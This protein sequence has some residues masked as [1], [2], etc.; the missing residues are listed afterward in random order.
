[1]KSFCVNI[2]WHGLSNLYESLASQFLA[3]L[4]IV[5]KI[6]S[7]NGLKTSCQTRKKE[8][9]KEKKKDQKKRKP[10]GSGKKEHSQE[11]LGGKDHFNKPKK[12]LPLHLKSKLPEK[13]SPL[14]RSSLFPS[15]DR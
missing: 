15:L 7:W 14:K 11:K 8:K 10:Y 1:M 12:K 13:D 3:L 4:W 6:K 2:L 5:Q 9:R